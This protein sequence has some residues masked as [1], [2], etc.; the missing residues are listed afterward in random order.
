MLKG[1]VFGGWVKRSDVFLNDCFNCWV[2]NR[3]QSPLGSSHSGLGGLLSIFVLAK[4]A[5][6][7]WLKK[8]KKGTI[9]CDT[10]KSI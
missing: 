6:Y 1:R 8:I 10:L 4:N 3:V 7:K 2:E 5:N 9:F